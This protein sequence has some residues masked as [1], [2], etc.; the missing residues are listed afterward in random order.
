MSVMAQLSFVYARSRLASYRPATEQDVN[1]L[2]GS[3]HRTGLARL[4]LGCERC[5]CR[6]ALVDRRLGHSDQLLKL[7]RLAEVEL[8]GRKDL[9][10]AVHN[11]D[12]NQLARILTQRTGERLG[13]AAFRLPL[14]RSS[15]P[16]R[17]PVTDP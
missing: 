10:L 15:F 13:N 16:D 9:V 12:Q 8:G 14:H 6:H 4:A 3:A 1:S 17:H 5:I 7:R 2:V 11:F